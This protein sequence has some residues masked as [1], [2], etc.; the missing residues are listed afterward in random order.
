MSQ[1]VDENEEYEVAETTRDKDARQKNSLLLNLD[2]ISVVN[3]RRTEAAAL[4]SSRVVTTNRI[5]ATTADGANYGSSDRKRS[6][7][8]SANKQLAEAE[9]ARSTSPT[10]VSLLIKNR[11]NSG[12]ITLFINMI[13]A[14]FILNI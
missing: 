5:V 3:E 9:T 13:L 8:S 7:C 14:C 1:N 12:M 2:R 11:F 4:D 10:A 6:S